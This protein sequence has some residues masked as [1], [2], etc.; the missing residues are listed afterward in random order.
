MYITTVEV[1]DSNGLDIS[2]K[3]I[4]IKEMIRKEEVEEKDTLFV[5]SLEWFHDKFLEWKRYLIL[6]LD[7][8]EQVAQKL[9]EDH[10]ETAYVNTIIVLW[11]ER[12][13]LKTINIIN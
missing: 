6:R 4:T 3:I 8:S 5:K 7:T 12:K 10:R 13:I 1:E 9:I 11:E 2:L